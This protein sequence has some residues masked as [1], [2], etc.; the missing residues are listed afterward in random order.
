MVPAQ[1]LWVTAFNSAA[2]LASYGTSVAPLLVHVPEAAVGCY[3]LGA[4]LHIIGHAQLIASSGNTCSIHVSEHAPG[5][6]V[7]AA[8]QQQFK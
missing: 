5:T 7:A 2:G 3:S 8:R 6:H 4:V 1:Q